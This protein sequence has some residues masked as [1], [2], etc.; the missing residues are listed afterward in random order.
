VINGRTEYYLLPGQRAVVTGSI[1]LVDVP[2]DKDTVNFW[3]GLIH[4]D[5][6]IDVFNDHVDPQP[7]VIG[8]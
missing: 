5:V 3:A 1:T 4:E 8:F 2:A 6:R 7:I